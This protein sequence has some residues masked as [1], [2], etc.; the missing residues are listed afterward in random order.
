MHFNDEMQFEINSKVPK[1]T[2]NLNK[3][4]FEIKVSA[5]YELTLNSLNKLNMKSYIFLVLFFVS[6]I[7]FCQENLFS[8]K[9][10]TITEHIDGTLLVPVG[11]DSKKTDLAIII[12]G[13]GP[14][15]RNGNQNF[16]KNN[17]LK[18]LAESLSNKGIASF[19]YDKRIVKQIRQGNVDKNIMF[20]D[21]VNDATDIIDYFKAKDIYNKI[22]VIGHSQ[23]SLVG[24]L[25]AKDK[26]DGFISLA[27]PGQNIGDVLVEQATKMDPK[28][29][30][31]TQPVIDQLKQ[32]KTVTD[33]PNAL[34]SVF[35]A[36]IQ[37]FMI[38]W[39]EYYPTELIKELD[40]PI[41]L[42]NGTKDLQVS[43]NEAELLKAA[44]KK[45]TLKIIENM[46][47]VLF[48]IKGDN[49]ENSKSYNESFR[50]ISPQLIIS[51]TEFMSS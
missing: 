8:E 19:R 28:L 11:S 27:G 13:S 41:L 12:A 39:M 17:S 48:E 31:L 36:D 45:A 23:G 16:L 42:I 44:N 32:G 30:E 29:G 2:I 47:H 9:E 35:K 5:L 34:E 3:T 21:F 15:N 26:A 46:N 24:M 33:Y 10:L 49:L 43:E 40:M 22:Y 25:A 14:T 37:P 6:S 50:P 4:S 51:I 18:K 38:N 1:N 20:D 7:G